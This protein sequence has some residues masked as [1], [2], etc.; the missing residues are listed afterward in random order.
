MQTRGARD[1]IARRRVLYELPRLVRGSVVAFDELNSADYP[2]ETV[3]MVEEL[4]VRQCDLF[5]SAILPDR[6][7]MV[8]V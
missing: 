5:R 7:Y 3:A 6:S 1:T 8:I 4:G 2:G